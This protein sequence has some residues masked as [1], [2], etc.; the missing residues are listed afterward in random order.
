MNTAREIE[1]SERALSAA[2]DLLRDGVSGHASRVAHDQGKHAVMQA[3]ATRRKVRRNI[4]PWMAAAAAV[5]VMGVGASMLW[6]DDSLTYA[7]FSAHPSEDGFIALEESAKQG[8]VRFSDGTVVTVDHGARVQV[9][10]VDA[11]GA[12]LLVDE[13]RARFHVIHKPRARW[14]VAAGPYA[15]E[16]TGTRFEVNW[17]RAKGHFELTLEDG[18]VVVRG[19]QIR[20]GVRLSAGQTLIASAN[21]PTVRIRDVHEGEPVVTTTAESDEQVLPSA[22]R[23]KH[24]PGVA[25]APSPASWSERVRSGEF[26]SVIVEARARGLESVLKRAPLA[27]LVALADA[28][29][30]SHEAA[31]SERALRAQRARFARSSH[32][33][34]A[35]FLLG[36]LSEDRGDKTAAALRWYEQYLREAPRGAFASEALGRKMVALHR[37]EGL[38][39]ALPVARDYVLRFPSGPYAARARELIQAE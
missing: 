23:A 32:A 4:A 27:D 36:R 5:V 15:V 14:N 16:V 38:E 26:E 25:K 21:P 3:F 2:A 6:R 39:G 7:G 8:G 29:R 10:E 34:D 17:T 13:G 28:A 33:R 31:V 24:A 19:P 11:L 37:S 18:S 1:D 20:D 35:A 22:T 9:V 30:Y 12:E